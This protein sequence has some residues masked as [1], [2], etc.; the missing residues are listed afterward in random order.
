MSDKVVVLV[1]GGVVQQV[2][3]SKR[4]ARD[5]E[6]GVIDWDLLEEMGLDMEA[7]LEAETEGLEE[8]L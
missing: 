6:A 7:E 3:I 8:V 1:K 5:I 4:L 2:Y